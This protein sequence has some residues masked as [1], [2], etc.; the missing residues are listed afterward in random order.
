MHASMDTLDSQVILYH[1]GQEYL[2]MLPREKNIAICEHCLPLMDQDGSTQK[3]EPEDQCACLKN[4]VRLL[5]CVLD[6]FFRRMSRRALISITA[7]TVTS[8]EE[9][10]LFL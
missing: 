4:C 7:T 8:T 5:N 2:C 3:D 9:N 1:Q 10:K 6:S